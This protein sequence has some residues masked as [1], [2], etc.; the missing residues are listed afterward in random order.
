M[1]EEYKRLMEAALRFLAYRPRS[2]SEVRE[3]LSKKNT[4]EELVH[5]VL[6]KLEASKLIND[7][8]FG[9]WLVESRSRSRPRGARLLRRELQEK[10]LEKDLITQLVS[11]I[12]ETE[13][14][15]RALKP[16]ID[17]FKKLPLRQSRTKAFQFLA[18]KGFSVSAIELAIKKAYND[19]NVN[20]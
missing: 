16:K 8:E 9:S 17:K 12:N 14:A 5:R 7:Q 10:G 3:H 18:M 19:D 4:S 15:F 2:S 11:N 6:A 1:D 13:L 20:Y